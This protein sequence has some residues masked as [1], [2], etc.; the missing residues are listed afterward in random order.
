MFKKELPMPLA[1][2]AIFLETKAMPT[3]YRAIDIVTISPSIKK[4]LKKMGYGVDNTIHI[5]YPGVNEIAPLI[6]KT[7]HPSLIYLGRLREY[8]HVDVLIRMAAKLKEEFPT[9]QVTIAGDGESTKKLTQLSEKLRV[10]NMVTFTGKI[11]EK[12]KEKLLAKSWIAIHPSIAEGW[13]ITNIEANLCGTPVVASDIDGLRDSVVNGKTGYLVKPMSVEAFY[14]ATRKLLHNH[15]LRERMA[16]ESIIWAQNFSWDASAKSGHPFRAWLARF[17]RGRRR[18]ISSAKSSAKCLFSLCSR[19]RALP[20]ARLSF[21]SSGFE[22][23]FLIISATE[24]SSVTFIP[25]FKSRPRFISCS[26]QSSGTSA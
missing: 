14:I 17:R 22:D 25:P 15:K 4:L 13:G 5:V 19:T 1:Q 2:I 11:S 21:G 9:L 10:C 8:K 12:E 3:V 23:I 16:M 24:T 18:T 6:K 26:L 7:S 20:T